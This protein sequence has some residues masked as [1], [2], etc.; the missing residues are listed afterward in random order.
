MNNSATFL[1]NFNARFSAPETVA[2]SFIPPSNFDEVKKFFNSLII[3]PRESG[4]TTLLKMLTPSAI[5][6]WNSS[7]SRS[8]RA[9]R[10]EYI[11][12]Y[13][14][15]DNTMAAQIANLQQSHSA[16][17]RPVDHANFGAAFVHG[18]FCIFLLQ[19]MVKTIREITGITKY[20]SVIRR[21]E[22]NICTNISKIWKIPTTSYS[23]DS[24]ALSVREKISEIHEVFNQFYLGLITPEEVRTHLRTSFYSLDPIQ[25]ISQTVAAI[26]EITGLERQKWAFLFDE[27]E[28]APLAIKRKLL[29]A[30]R[31]TAEQ[32]FMIKLTMAPY[33]NSF[34]EFSNQGGPSAGNDFD[35]IPLWYPLK[36]EGAKFCSQIVE[37]MMTERGFG[38]Q[39]PNTLLGHSVYYSEKSRKAKN[40]EYGALI[41]ALR[42][43]DQSFEAFARQH[44]DIYDDISKV[45]EEDK[46]AQYL[47]KPLSVMTFRSY[48]LKSWSTRQKPKFRSRKSIE[49]YTGMEFIFAIT[50]GNPRW[51]IGLMN[52]LLGHC[53]GNS[54]SITKEKQQQE[55]SNLMNRYRALLKAYTDGV[56]GASRG[57]LS[58]LDR[59]GD[60]FSDKF[61]SEA[62]NP[63][64]VFS[65]TVDSTTDEGVLRDISVALNAGAIIYQPHG[66]A[67]NVLSSVKGKQFRLSYLLC[68]QYKIPLLSGRAISLRSLLSGTADQA[69]D[70]AQQQTIFE[71]L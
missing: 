13:I 19:S 26:N 31:S 14:P 28:L 12:V 61:Y 24:L 58:L 53:S 5:E 16:S 10:I 57:L 46:R 56:A 17:G 41:K 71:N 52:K 48:F 50:E 11:G 37:S 38:G 27:I 60:A 47:R 62:Y 43:V 59:I 55:I 66:D 7:S 2:R 69:G 39:S 54:A 34:T 29:G 68:P 4:K 23:I 22:E 1:D 63:D 49:I 15:Y 65:F 51:L 64:P 25:A 45:T 20:A 8:H 36:E 44:R 35:L 30:M 42:T 6:A 3:G 32:R 18:S 67:H 21:H 33:D 70:A 9:Y 40:E